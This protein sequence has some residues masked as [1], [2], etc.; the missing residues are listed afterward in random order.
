[1]KKKIDFEITEDSQKLAAVKTGGELFASQG[2]IALMLTEFVEN[3]ND[4]IKAKQIQYNKKLAKEC[5]IVEINKSL[6]EIRI[7]DTGT[8]ILQPIHIC[9]KPFISLKSNEDYTTGKFGR[10]SQVFRGFCDTLQFI[11]LREFPHKEEMDINENPSNCIKLTFEKNE[12]NGIYEDIPESDFKKYCDYDTGTIAILTGWTDNDFE[13]VL[14]KKEQIMTRLQHHFGFELKDGKYNIKIIIKMDNKLE[15][16]LPRDYSGS[17]IDGEYKLPSMKLLSPHTKRSYGHIE[18]H[19]FKTTR[20]YRHYFKKPFLVVDNRPLGNS[21]ISEIPELSDITD[22]WSSNFITGYII[23]NGVKTNQLRVGLDNQDESKSLFINAVQHITADFKKQ[24]SAWRQLTIQA[25]DNLITQEVATEI[26]HFF[27][28]KG[29]KLNFKNT[30]KHGASK[31]SKGDSEMGKVSST[32][33]HENDGMIDPKS[34]DVE[35]IQFRKPGEHIRVKVKSKKRTTG[36]DHE[37]EIKINRALLSKGGSRVRKIGTGPSIEFYN[38][39]IDYD[40]ISYY[41]KEPPTV[42]INQQNRAWKNL[43]RK[44]MNESGKMD[45][46][47]KR[48]MQE[49]YMWELVQNC[50]KKSDDQNIEDLFWNT[51]HDFIGTKI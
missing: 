24:I 35:N 20:K 27:K 15:N 36:G 43:S 51:Y 34:D 5:V 31:E 3:G 28:K 13:M 45:N 47:K 17:L 1:M 16:I 42:F 8:G 12:A 2:G 23:C 22:I 9:K 46:L 26:Q 4:A 50:Y 19:I 33:G 38:N 32:V 25:T 48:Y 44:T 37:K 49:R 10:G 41:E 7:I 18:F 11:T 40:E 29:I 30:L 14:K 39:E 6:K 21:F